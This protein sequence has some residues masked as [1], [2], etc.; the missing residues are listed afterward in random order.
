MT[1]VSELRNIT[2]KARGENSNGR[3]E[4][5]I[6][7]RDEAFNLMTDG[8][9][10]R[11]KEAA[12]NGKFRYPIYRWQNTPRFQKDDDKKQ[13]DTEDSLDDT[14][15]FFG[16]SSD[17]K[18]GL[19][20][21]PLTNPTGIDRQHSLIT[22]LREFFNSGSDGVS[23]D[24]ERR[25]NQLKVYFERHPIHFGKCAIFVSWD[26]KH[27]QRP[28]YAGSGGF[29]NVERK[30]TSNGSLSNQFCTMKGNDPCYACMHDDEIQAQIQG[31][32]Q[33]KRFVVKGIP[34]DRKFVPRAGYVKRA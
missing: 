8:V 3:L 11:I 27:V 10:D 9:M 13:E 2:L 5:Y 20:I 15:V 17:G 21:M 28:S 23:S 18:N 12:S 22:K 33:K 14:K 29:E 7:A 16:N 6:K 25:D 26:K 32:I 31:S 34:N 24:E 4:Q 1:T 30:K 19:H